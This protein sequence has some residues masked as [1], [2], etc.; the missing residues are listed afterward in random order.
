MIGFDQD[1]LQRFVFER[2]RVRGEI[3]RLD[4]SWREMLRRHDYPPGVRI[5][6]G[7]LM[8]ASALLAATLKIQGGGL[9]LQIQGGDPVGLLVVECQADLTLRGTA[10][11]NRGVL[12][13]G[14][15]AT[16]RA[17]T[18]GGRCVLTIDPGQQGMQL[19]QSVV[20]LEG[21]TT[22]EVLRRYMERSEQ[23]DTRFVL[24]ADAQR[25]TGLLLQKMPAVGGTA[26]TREDEGLW[27]RVAARV[28]AV[29][30][31]DLLTKPLNDVLQQLLQGDEL[32]LFESMK[33]RFQCRC[34]R[35][36]VA[37]VIRMIGAEEARSV[38]AE[39]G[40]ISIRCEFCGEAYAFDADE[41][42]AALADSGSDTPEP[43][44]A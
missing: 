35:D 23:I 28:D 16:L 36:R 8:A 38:I 2:A 1:C 13:L 11:Y 42:E 29:A 7:E 26:P 9:V 33:A 5:A 25:A 14:E 37:G 10:M 31:E 22:A 17:L 43:A 3:V 19:Y 39:Q 4:A 21:G 40:K 12:D 32:Q 41:T 34:S 6:L 44:E 18:R 30:R 24:A 20:P 27:D 15:N